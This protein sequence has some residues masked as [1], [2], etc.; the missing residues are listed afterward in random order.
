MQRR[1]GTE[2][3][4]VPIGLVARC[5]GAGDT[6]CGSAYYA[7]PGHT[8][9]RT[10]HNALLR[11]M[12]QRNASLRNMTQH[13]A[14]LRNMT[15]HNS[16]AAYTLAGARMEGA[17]HPQRR[18]LAGAGHDHADADEYDVAARAHRNGSSVCRARN[19]P[20]R[21]QLRIEAETRQCLAIRRPRVPAVCTAPA[22]PQAATVSY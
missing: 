6:V 19:R 8:T 16:R 15:Q 13:N 4:P 21:Q 3:S 20:L 7:R 11:N 5:V 12:T 10:Q 18:Q 22:A 17:Q 1:G 14:S 2:S 9:S